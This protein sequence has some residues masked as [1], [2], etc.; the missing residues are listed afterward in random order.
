MAEARRPPRPTVRPEARPAGTSARESEPRGAQAR[1]QSSTLVA[2][3]RPRGAVPVSADSEELARPWQRVTTG[4]R[5]GG[6]AAD[7]A[8]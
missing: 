8:G 5:P 4:R 1:P 2:G 7:V 6:S 3:E